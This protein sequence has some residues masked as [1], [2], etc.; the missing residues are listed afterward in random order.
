MSLVL[1]TEK[2]TVRGMIGSPDT[3]EL[4]DATL[5]NFLTV[6]ALAWINDKRPAKAITSFETIADQQD[7]DEKPAVALK[8]TKVWWLDS[9][10]LKF[11]PTMEVVPGSMS[12]TAQFTGMSTIDNPEMVAMFYKKINYYQQF[13]QG[14]GK[15]TEEGKI[16]LI[17]A[18]GNAG[19]AVFFEYSYPL[20][21]IIN[22]QNQYVD[23]VRN[24][25]A[26][27][28]LKHLAIKRG[29]IRSGRGWS[30]GGGAMEMAM[31]KDYENKAE[32]QV[33]TVGVISI[34]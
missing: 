20:T 12:L 6:N 4:P 28:A 10:W 15:E 29:V 21:A 19:D 14:Y 22:V 16:R 26:S 5:E 17:P 3:T 8:V 30:G 11:S 27:F 33:P 2:A 13:F 23:G 32:A 1:V 7:Y 34:G 18:P 31:A 25:A 9:S 24:I